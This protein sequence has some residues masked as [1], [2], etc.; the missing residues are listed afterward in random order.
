MDGRL[1]REFASGVDER[2]IT[3]I[4]KAVADETDRSTGTV[5][6]LRRKVVQILATEYGIDP[7]GVMP[8]RTTFYRLVAAVSRGPAHVRVGA[9]P[10]VVGAAARTARS[11]R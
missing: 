2:V 11:A 9:D 6:R 7:A 3:A 4:E 10:A 5:T 1:T 8:P